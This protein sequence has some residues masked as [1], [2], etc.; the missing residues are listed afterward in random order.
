MRRS[1]S[2]FTL[3]ELLVVIVMIGLLTAIASTAY[4]TSQ[5]RSRDSARKTAVNGISAAVESYYANTQT[6][7]GRP[8]LV[9]A[10][11]RPVQ[12]PKLVGCEDL[13]GWT[14]AGK[15]YDLY[16]YAY[17]PVSPACNTS[18]RT[19]P[20]QFSPAPSWIPGL[21]SYLNPFPTEGQYQDAAGGTS[22]TS[23]ADFLCSLATCPAQG[24]NQTRTIV[25]HNLGSGYAVYARLESASDVDALASGTIPA[26]AGVPSLPPGF[27]T[28]ASGES[29]YLVRK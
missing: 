17:K 20:T 19:N 21:G 24:A 18:T 7:P 13:T 10:T 4:L 9:D 29:V 28:I 8:L 12:D 1:L 11:T 3:I 22:A 6:F 25:Y 23:F 26:V 27:N 5:R 15:S 14:S 2:G 16:T